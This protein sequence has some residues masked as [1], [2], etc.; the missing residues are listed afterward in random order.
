M[1]NKVVA[2]RL[3]QFAKLRFGSIANLERGMN[4]SVRSLSQY[5]AGNSK[6]GAV[7]IER[8]KNVG[9]DVEWL[10]FG[11]KPDG[12]V[13]ESISSYPETSDVL[14]KALRVLMMEWRAI[15][16]EIEE[17]RAQLNR[18]ERMVNK[19]YGGTDED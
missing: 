6:P 19:N 3:K 1:E 13:G 12:V 18:I 17:T 5:V 9:C 7:L 4:M 8:L 11:D 10:L 15:K 2:D 16:K 14:E